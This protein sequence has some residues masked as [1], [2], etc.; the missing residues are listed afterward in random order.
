MFDPSLEAD[1]GPGG[2]SAIPGQEYLLYV[3]WGGTLKLDLRSSSESDKFRYTWIDLVDEAEHTGGTIA[4][5][6]VR[7][8]QAPEGYPQVRRIKD[9]ILYI[10]KA[11]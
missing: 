9:W 2:G 8:F 6:Q 1:S 10:A 11:R 3:R 5:G 7:Q 4:G